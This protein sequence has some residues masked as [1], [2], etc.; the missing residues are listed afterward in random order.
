MSATTVMTVSFAAYFLPVFILRVL[1]P[2]LVLFSTA[3]VLFTR[4][5]T[6]LSPSPITSVVVATHVPRR[7]VIL[8]LL[9]LSALTFLFDGLTFVIHAVVTKEWLHQTGIE[10]NAIV[11]LAAFAGLAA[12]G[13]WKDIQG[14]EVWSL[15]R[16]KATIAA[17][18][19]LDTAL[20][21]LLGLQIKFLKDGKTLSIYETIL[22]I[23]R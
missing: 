17:T 22:G 19:G 1:S 12:V 5:S 23:L 14:V 18:L 11:G 15:K 7:A 2:V 8:T 13:S 20:V 21:I 10:I 16:I 4:P 6:P 9:S 3:S